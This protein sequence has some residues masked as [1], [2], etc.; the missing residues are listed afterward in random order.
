MKVCNKD[1]YKGHEKFKSWC[2]PCGCACPIS[3]C[4]WSCFFPVALYSCL[5][6]ESGD[7][8]GSAKRVQKL[9]SVCTLWTVNVV[10]NWCY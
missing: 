9:R 8:G 2:V 4:C 7:P 3:I 6:S 1:P 5:T 10:T